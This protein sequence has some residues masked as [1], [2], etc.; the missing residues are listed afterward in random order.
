MGLVAVVVVAQSLTSPS[1]AVFLLHVLLEAPLIVQGFWYPQSLPFLGMNNTALV[2]IKVCNSQIVHFRK[3]QTASS[4][5]AALERDKLGHMHHF[6][7]VL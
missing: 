1:S 6:S 2:L 4:C 3:T 7:L 5:G